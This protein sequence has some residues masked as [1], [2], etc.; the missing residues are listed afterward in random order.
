MKG[1]RTGKILLL[2]ECVREEKCDTVTL[3]LSLLQPS[4]TGAN[5]TS[6][7]L[8][9]LQRKQSKQTIYFFYIN[10]NK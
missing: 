10:N 3:S 7:D 1:G 8:V 4:L 6:E 2:S 9:I 5:I